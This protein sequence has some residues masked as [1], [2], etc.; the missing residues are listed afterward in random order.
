[1]FGFGK[2]RPVFIPAVTPIWSETVQVPGPAVF[3]LLDHLDDL[4]IAEL[5]K[6]LAAGG[7]ATPAGKLIVVVEAASDLDEFGRTFRKYAS[8]V[9]QADRDALDDLSMAT[10]GFAFYKAVGASPARMLAEDWKTNVGQARGVR[11]LNGGLQLDGH[12]VA[13]SIAKTYGQAL[14]V[15][16]DRMEDPAPRERIKER[17]RGLF[18]SEP[19]PATSPPVSQGEFCW[20]SPFFITDL[21]DQSVRFG[22]CRVL[23]SEAPLLVA[24]RPRNAPIEPEALHEGIYLP[25][26]LCSGSDPSDCFP[27]L[28]AIMKETMHGT[29]NG[30]MRPLVVFAPELGPM[31]LALFVVNNLRRSVPCCALQPRPGLVV[32]MGRLAENHG[33]QQLATRMPD[34]S[35]FW[36]HDAEGFYCNHAGI[37]WI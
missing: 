6:V 11:L 37:D 16:L 34:G 20:A 13:S 32:D 25:E 17:Y 22:P 19:R 30:E 8:M 33:L 23:V 28:S 36:S 7:N 1:M 12:A 27:I 5:E 31:V 9:L 3:L 4:D 24:H 18:G 14:Q 29:E 15:H 26:K 21:A 35:R 10:G 2:K